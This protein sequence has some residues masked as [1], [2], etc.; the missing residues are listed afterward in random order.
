MPRPGIHT[1]GDDHLLKSTPCILLDVEGTT[2]SIS[3]V[4]DVL[5][6]YARERAAEFLRENALA[7][8]VR[9]I[10][11]ELRQQR[12][13]DERQGLQP[14][15][16]GDD[17]ASVLRYVYWLMD[18]DS[19][20]TPLKSLQ[21]LMWEQGYRE[22]KLKSHVYP[23]VPQAF[24]RWKQAGKKI[25]IFSSGSV[26][27]QK[28]LFAHTEAGDLTRYISGYFDTTIGTKRQAASYTAIARLLQCEPRDVT[29]VSDVLEELDAASQAGM[30][31]VL[32]VR[33]GNK[34][35]R[36]NSYPQVRTFEGL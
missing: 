11:A 23:D 16:G 30:Q 15:P 17:D 18:R 2:T 22:G 35:Q 34:E 28:Q 7:D 20:A 6:P 32:A 5:F 19:K 8:Q 9:S 14:P 27:A 25:A 31:A 29:F 12:D 3:F 33:P 1:A 10:V 21:G 13:A 26:L 24:E 4:Y 36:E